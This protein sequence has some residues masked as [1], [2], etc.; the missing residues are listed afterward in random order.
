LLLLPPQV[1]PCWE[2]DEQSTIQ[3]GLDDRVRK[4]QRA[5]VLLRILAAG[6]QSPL[7]CA[8]QLGALYDQ[9]HSL[10]ALSCSKEFLAFLILCELIW[11]CFDC[12]RS[13]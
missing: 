1:A 9:P 12:E 6:Q 4:S 2:Q 5:H 3:T 10:S 13:L 11:F 7:W 8:D